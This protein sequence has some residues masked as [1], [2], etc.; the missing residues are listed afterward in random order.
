MALLVQ[1]D[2][3][4]GAAG[5]FLGGTY[6]LGGASVFSA[7]DH[8]LPRGRPTPAAVPILER[9][10][11]NMSTTTLLIIIVLLLVLGGGGFYGRGRWY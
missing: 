11:D 6:R 1:T 7:S 5:V 9:R 2:S 8:A 3:S 4:F 10:E